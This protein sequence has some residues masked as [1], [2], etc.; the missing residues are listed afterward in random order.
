M[1]T[2][3]ICLEEIIA[4]V[5]FEDTAERQL[6]SSDSVNSFEAS[7]ELGRVASEQECLADLRLRFGDNCIT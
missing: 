7:G 3:S 4:T 6:P 2:Q 1:I 5:P